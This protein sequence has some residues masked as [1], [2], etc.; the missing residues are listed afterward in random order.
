[1][2]KFMNNLHSAFFDVERDSYRQDTRDEIIDP[3]D[4]MERERLDEIEAV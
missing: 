2:N 1:M 3:I 4:P